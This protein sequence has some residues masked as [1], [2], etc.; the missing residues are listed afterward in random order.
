MERNNTG[1]VG[2]PVDTPHGR[3]SSGSSSEPRSF[4]SSSTADFSARGRL[5]GSPTATFA[6][7]E[8]QEPEQ[9]HRP[10]S[11]VDLSSLRD[12]LQQVWRIRKELQKEELPWIRDFFDR[13]QFCFPKNFGEVA[14]RLNLNIPF[15]A[16]NYAVIFYTVTL[17]FLIFYDPLFFVLFCV[18]A[19]LVHSIQLSRKKRSRYGTT[20]RIGGISVHYQ[21]LADIYF[22]ALLLLFVFGHGLRTVGLVLLIN[23]VLIIPHALLRRPTYFDDEELEKMRPKVVQYIITLVLLLL[24]YLECKGTGGSF[25]GHHHRKEGKKKKKPN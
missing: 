3:D 15:F 22:I 11:A 8:E 20:M 2:G 5:P 17:P 10:Q 13:E 6:S 23:T 25:K 1:G 24:A 19:L 18:S 16:A 4:A 14:S 9:G 21:R 7:T 12:V